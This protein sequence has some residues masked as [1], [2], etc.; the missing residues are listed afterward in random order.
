MAAVVERILG[1]KL[2]VTPNSRSTTSDCE[3]S[4]TALLISL[5]PYLPSGRKKATL[6]EHTFNPQPREAEALGSEN[7]RSA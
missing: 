1:V 3:D 6:I 4:G 7:L 5:D 2:D